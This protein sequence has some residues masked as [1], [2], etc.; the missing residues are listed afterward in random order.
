M[1]R[2]SQFP[3]AT[4]HLSFQLWLSSLSFSLSLLCF[5]ISFLIFI[6]VTFCLSSRPPLPPVFPFL[7]LYFYF[8]LIWPLSLSLSIF[9]HDHPNYFKFSVIPTSA[10]SQDWHLVTDD[11][12]TMLWCSWFYKV[13]T[14]GWYPAHLEYHV[15]DFRQCLILWSVLSLSAGHWPSCGMLSPGRSRWCNF[16]TLQCYSHRIVCTTPSGFKSKFKEYG[17]DSIA[18]FL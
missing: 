4:P 13:R 15:M 17:C 3:I 2:S 10:I 1:H 16:Q 18:I 11:S 5:T 12:V 9:S 6:S 8:L 14:L 7:V